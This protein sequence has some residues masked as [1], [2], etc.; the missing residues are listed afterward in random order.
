MPTAVSRWPPK[1]T[2]TLPAQAARQIGHQFGIIEI[3]LAYQQI[4]DEENLSSLLIGPA[5]QALRPAKG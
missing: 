2:A 5:C 1:V 3:R 4:H